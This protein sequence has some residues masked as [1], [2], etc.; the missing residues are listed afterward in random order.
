[1]DTFASYLISIGLIAFGVSIVIFGARTASGSVLVWTILGLMPVV[2]GL[3]S[4]IGEARD[5]RG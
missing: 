1:M 5:G 3:V 4:L 2:L